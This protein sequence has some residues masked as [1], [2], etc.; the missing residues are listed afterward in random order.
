MC[1]PWAFGG[2]RIRVPLWV[3]RLACVY[4]G[5]SLSVFQV[6]TITI[7]YDNQCPIDWIK[8]CT[9]FPYPERL[10]SIK[11]IIIIKISEKE[12]QAQGSKNSILKAPTCDRHHPPTESISE[13]V[14]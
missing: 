6:S 7:N 1:G 12:S 9:C 4:S 11:I 3:C 2:K 13:K 14:A 8:I 5:K 10:G